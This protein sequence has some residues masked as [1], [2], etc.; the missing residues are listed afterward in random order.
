MATNIWGCP[1]CVWSCTSARDGF[2]YGLIEA[3][4]HLEHREEAQGLFPRDLLA[5]TRRTMWQCPFEHDRRPYVV[6]WASDGDEPFDG[7]DENRF[8]AGDAD[9]GLVLIAQHMEAMHTDV[10]YRQWD[11]ED[12][13]QG[14][15]PAGVLGKL[16]R[17]G[18]RGSPGFEVPG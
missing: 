11:A 8:W 2:D 16:R 10:V 18:V 12:A 13:P 14:I 7:P 9:V 3:H 4:L 17:V 5:L 15:I 6:T 1:F